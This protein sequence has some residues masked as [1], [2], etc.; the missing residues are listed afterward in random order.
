MR[1]LKDHSDLLTVGMSQHELEK[2]IER[3]IKRQ[4][5]LQYEKRKK[6]LHK[7]EIPGQSAKPLPLYGQ[8]S[9]FYTRLNVGASNNASTLSL[10]VGGNNGQQASVDATP[11]QI[12][13]DA[14]SL[15]GPR[16]T[17]KGVEGNCEAEVQTIPDLAMESSVG[18]RRG[19]AT[20]MPVKYSQ[21]SKDEGTRRTV[22]VYKVDQATLAKKIKSDTDVTQESNK[23]EK[24]AAKGQDD[25]S[26][27]D[28]QTLRAT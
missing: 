21:P 27:A 4:N 13:S 5:K 15:A 3:L 10:V 14:V 11:F 12:H 1:E 26:Y 22:T 8:S 20:L 28:V 9:H 16:D 2:K 17:A 23:Y 18:T 25:S 24:S 7:K 19:S 6:P